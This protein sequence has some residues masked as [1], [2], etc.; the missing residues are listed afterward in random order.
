[1]PLKNKEDRFSPVFPYNEEEIIETMEH[2]YAKNYRFYSFH[3]DPKTMRFCCWLCRKIIIE[4][5]GIYIFERLPNECKFIVWTLCKQ[6]KPKWNNP[7]TYQILWARFLKNE[8]RGN[9]H[10]SHTI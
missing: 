4:E 10:S 8:Q 5:G 2:L 7:K 6:C 9:W 3:S 1:M